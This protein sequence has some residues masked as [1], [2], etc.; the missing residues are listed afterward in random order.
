MSIYVIDTPIYVTYFYDFDNKSAKKKNYSIDCFSNGGFVIGVKVICQFCAGE[1]RNGA[2]GR[3]D[4]VSGIKRGRIFILFHLLIRYSCHFKH[5]FNF[6]F[7]NITTD[8]T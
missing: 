3:V 6:N 5:D 7:K 4:S 2:G 8:I 1:K